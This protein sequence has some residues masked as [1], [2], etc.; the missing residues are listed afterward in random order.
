MSS[1]NQSSTG[2]VLQVGGSIWLIILFL[3]A[4]FFLGEHDFSFSRN[5]VDRYTPTEDEILTG[6]TEGSLVRRIAFLSLG[7]FAVVSL[8]RRR[9]GESFRVNSFLGGML[10][11][12]V[13]WAFLSVIWA[14]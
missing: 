14:E 10:L 11:A 6:A 9:P 8:A 13:S 5:V 2:P 7:V 1:N 12:F 4:V 3:S